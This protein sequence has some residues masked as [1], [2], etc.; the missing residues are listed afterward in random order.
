MAT[1]HRD[2][3]RPITRG[4]VR[5]LL[6]IVITELGA[7]WQERFAALQAEV[8][9]LKSAQSPQAATFQLGGDSMSGQINIDTEDESGTVTLTDKAGN[10]VTI[11]GVVA[12]YASDNEAVATV[13]ADP[14]NPLKVKVTPVGL[15]TANVSVTSL[16][17]ATGAALLETD[18]VTPIPMPGSALV[19]VTAG[20][21]DGATFVLSE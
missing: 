6:E 8:D 14:T 19:T 18:G 11:D 3:N 15:G 5:N 9:A 7:R 16:V 12:A 13:A 1:D 17:D 2:D 21:A 4:Q 10:P 20:G